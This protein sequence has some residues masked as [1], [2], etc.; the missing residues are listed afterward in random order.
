MGG[1]AGCGLGLAAW[2]GWRAG[3]A[4]A[5]SAISAA[6]T[7]TGDLA[8]NPGIRAKMEL[9]SSF[10]ERKEG[11]DWQE[12]NIALTQIMSDYA[13]VGPY[14]VRSASLL[15]AGLSY[16]NQLRKET[17][18]S[19]KAS[20]SHTL[21]RAAE[22]LDL[23]DCAECILRS[24]LERKETRGSHKRSDFTFTNP[25]LADR[26]LDVTRR[27]DGTVVTSWREVRK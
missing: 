22:V 23:F 10:M 4:A 18:A 6:G 13:N 3:H 24:A 19:L 1:N 9:L 8:L 11:A 2:M 14:K 20:C 21:M 5:A 27:D 25:L 17:N 7:T 12:A 26:M 16:L 15:N